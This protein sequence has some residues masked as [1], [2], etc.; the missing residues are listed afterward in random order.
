M[1]SRLQNFRQ[2][3]QRKYLPSIIILFA[4][5]EQNSRVN[6][7]FLFTL[8]NVNNSICVHV[9]LSVSV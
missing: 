5:N 8:L 7:V 9:Y 3:E 2:G 1:A 6:Q 4:E